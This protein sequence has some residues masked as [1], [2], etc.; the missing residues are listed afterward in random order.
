MDL[1][2]SGLA[3]ASWT[4]RLSMLSSGTRGLVRPSVSELPRLLPEMGAK[5]DQGDAGDEACSTVL[6]IGSEGRAWGALRIVR[7]VGHAS[8]P[9]AAW[10]WVVSRAQ[11][12]VGKITE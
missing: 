3:E 11:S 1:G 2:W 8:S 9:I 6:T 4:L 5:D 12:R 10:R 7:K